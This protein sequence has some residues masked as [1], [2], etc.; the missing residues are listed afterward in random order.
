MKRLIIG[1]VLGLL[2]AAPACIAQKQLVLLKN[3]KVKLRLYIGD[4]I[5]YKE[6]GADHRRRS[7][8]SNVYDTAL[9]AHET[10]VPFHKIER[11]YFRQHSFANVIGGLFVIGGV[12]YFV[13]DQVNVSI[14]QGDPSLN[15]NVTRASIIMTAVGLPLMLIHKKSQRIGGKYRL[16]LADKGSPFFKPDLRRMESLMEN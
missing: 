6:K 14:I 16:L 8:V 15:Q 11:I 7:Y 5:I 4:E 10:M 12:G 3:E 9:L 2:M 13:V 1:M